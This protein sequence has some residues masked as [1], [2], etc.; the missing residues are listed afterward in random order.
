MSGCTIYGEKKP[1]TLKSTTSAEQYERIFWSA[2]KAKNWQQVPGCSPPTSCTAL[3]ARCSA[4][5]R[6]C[7]I[8]RGQHRRFH[9]Q[10]TGRQAK[11]S[12]HDA[13]LHLAAFPGR[14]A[15]PDLH[16]DQRLATGRPGL[17]P[18]RAHR[19][20]ANAVELGPA[21]SDTFDEWWLLVRQRSGSFSESCW[22]GSMPTRAIFPGGEALT[23]TAS[24]SPRS[25]CSRPG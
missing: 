16:R 20:A 18:H 6:S 7:P 15:G 2:V 3:G 10:R 4:R 21:P 19:T 9:H 25:C 8:C 5:I 23:P 11:R 12:G 1:P 14:W 24:G 17:D 13:Q 22:P